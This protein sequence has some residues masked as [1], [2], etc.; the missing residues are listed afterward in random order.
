[1]HACV[2]FAVFAL[3]TGGVGATQAAEA[4]AQ[5]WLSAHRAAQPDELADYAKQDPTGYALVKALLMKKS[6]GLLDPRHPHDSVS[7]NH[8]D[9][10]TPHT[11]VFAKFATPTDQ[12]VDSSAASPDAPAPTQHNWMSWKPADSGADDNLV[13]SVSGESKPE[14]KPEVDVAKAAPAEPVIAAAV[15]AE[16]VHS[17]P[18][19]GSFLSKK[20]DLTTYARQPEHVWKHLIDPSAVSVLTNDEMEFNIINPDVDEAAGT[21]AAPA[22]HP[23]ASMSQTNSFMKSI[24]FGALT[25]QQDDAPEVPKA[26]PQ[27]KPEPKAEA[28]KPVAAVAPVEKKKA[29][30]LND[31]GFAAVASSFAPGGAASS[32]SLAEEVA[33]ELPAAVLPSHHLHTR[34][35]LNEDVA[36]VSHSSPDDLTDFLGGG[37]LHIMG[38]KAAAHGNV[39]DRYAQDL[40]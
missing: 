16:P 36:T 26:A 30:F 32:R 31:I 13:K 21:E 11:N 1:M 20:H 23:Q 14:A 37:A 24:D 35:A 40:E 34:A 39:L 27:P 6:L 4:R 19:S 28:P 10:N 15:P 33:Q 5:V 3:V 2:L 29:S 38:R 17:T 12:S 22:Q 18:V 25:G 8:R 9:E 7:E